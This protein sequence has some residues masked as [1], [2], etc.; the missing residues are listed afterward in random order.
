[1]S[2]DICP[3]CF[4][5]LVQPTCARALPANRVELSLRCPECHLTTSGDYDWET[6]RSFGR[7]FAAG[8]AM[9]RATYEDL[10]KENFRDDLDCFVLALAS[11]L[12]GPDDFAP[13]RFNG[14]A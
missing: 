3:A 8:R 4:S 12:I 7:T 14:H 5:D 10:A 13:Y 2:L 1:M 11:D 9:L 6:A